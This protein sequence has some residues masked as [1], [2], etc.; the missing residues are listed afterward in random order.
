MTTGKLFKALRRFVVKC[1]AVN[2]TRWAVGQHPHSLLKNAAL[3]C[4][5][6]RL[7]NFKMLYIVF[8]IS[9]R[10]G[11]KGMRLHAK[12]SSSEHSKSILSPCQGGRIRTRDLLFPKQT[13]YLTA[14]HPG[15]INI[16]FLETLYLYCRIT[17]FV[18]ISRLFEDARAWRRVISG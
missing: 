8:S 1:L 4:L 6:F 5:H 16:R 18:T 2:N 11:K 12:S 7:H 15:H 10:T 13:R 3:L 14:L 9:R 17:K